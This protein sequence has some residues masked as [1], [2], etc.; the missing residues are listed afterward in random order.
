ML[1]TVELYL[2]ARYGYDTRCEVVMENGT[3]ALT[4]PSH[5]VTDARGQRGVHYPADW[6]PRYRDA[7]RL[8]LQEWID[9]IRQGRRSALACAE[10]GLRASLVADALIESMNS[11]GAWVSV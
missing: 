10:D 1:V 4:L 7:Y 6:I 8:E 3:A 11:H 9:S 5:I 2:N